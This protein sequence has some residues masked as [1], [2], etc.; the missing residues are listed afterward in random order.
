VPGGF[1]N[2]REVGGSYSRHGGLI[3]D[4]GNWICAATIYSLPFDKDL[5]VYIRVQPQEF[6]R[7]GVWAGGSNI[8]PPPGYERAITLGFQIVRLTASKP[9]EIVIFDMTFAP[10]PSMPR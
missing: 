9:S 4:G 8:Q 3:S 1:G 2:D 5:K 6:W 10:Q 7:T